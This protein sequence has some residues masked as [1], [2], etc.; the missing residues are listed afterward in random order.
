MNAVV[1]TSNG[2][3]EL[4]E[5]P[6]PVP[7][8]GE[9]LI[10][11]RRVGICSSDIFRGFAG[12][13][14]HYPLVMGHEISG[15]IVDQGPDTTHFSK[16]QDIVVFPL[17]PCGQCDACHDQQ[18]VHCLNYDYYGSRRDG[19]FQEFLV[20]KEWNLLPVP[21]TMAQNPYTGLCEPV[22]VCLHAVNMLPPKKNME[23]A[24]LG[25]GFLGMILAM[26]LQEQSHD[27]TLFD[28]NA[29]K[30]EMMRNLGFKGVPLASVHQYE[31]QFDAVIE[32][33]GAAITFQASLMIAAARGTVIWL[34]NAQESL[35]LD[36]SQISSVLR[37]ELQV[38]GTWNSNYQG[39]NRDDWADALS[40][41]ETASW[42]PSLISREIAL[43]QLPVTLG[44]MYKLKQYPEPHHILKVLVHMEKE[45]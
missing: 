18:W 27:V 38:R 37:K 43:S 41:I 14:Y 32:A 25:A 28:R 33:C 2:H 21:Q 34:G 4:Q 3:L 11:C 26:L 22:A 44:D 13:A 35:T 20:V 1:L 9:Y 19:G 24:V 23:I 40:L 39:G 10:R 36:K 6:I 29:F 45:G 30:L 16:G 7:Q 8:K 42:L 5:R 17:I 31:K 15:V 12:G